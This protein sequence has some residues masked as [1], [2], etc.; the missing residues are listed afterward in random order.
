MTKFDKIFFAEI[1][2]DIPL[3]LSIIMGVYPDLQN[4][5]LFYISLLTGSFASIYIIKTIKEG[6]YSPG[7]IEENPSVSF[8]FS[9]Y[10]IAL[11]FVL[12]YASFKDMLYMETYVWT[13]LIVFS[14][15]E[16]IFF[17]KSKNK[18]E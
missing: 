4:E 9:I 17:L 1:V 13:Y 18:S 11:I 3:W 8:S 14:A 7:I 15:L 5:K 16:L 6:E 10:S 2:Q 12:I